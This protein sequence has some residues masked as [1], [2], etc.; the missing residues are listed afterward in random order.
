MLS[1]NVIF[2]SGFDTIT[3]PFTHVT[4]SGNHRGRNHLN[5]HWNNRTCKSPNELLTPCELHNMNIEKYVQVHTTTP[6]GRTL[7]YTRMLQPVGL[8]HLVGEISHLVGPGL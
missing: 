4:F 6:Q 5:G 8:P 7:K 1:V 2:D 3:H